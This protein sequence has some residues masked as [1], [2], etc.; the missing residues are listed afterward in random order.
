MPT[1]Y[2]YAFSDFG[3]SHLYK[4]EIPHAPCPPGHVRLK[5]RAVSLN[6]RD[7]LMIKGAYNPRQELPLIPC[8][9]GVGQ[10]TEVG[11]SVTGFEPGDRVAGV[12]APEWQSGPPNSQNIRQTRG[13]PLPGMLTQEIVLPAHG[14][15]KV[16]EFLTDTQAATL[17]CA[18]LTAY[19]ALFVQGSLK[20]T[21]KVLI[22]GSGGVSLF[23]LQ[24]AKAAGAT[25]IATSS[26]D[27]KL[28]KLKLYGADHTIN[29]QTTPQWSRAVREITAGQ[30]VDHVVE[31]GGA[32]TLAQSLKS[33]GVGGTVS[34]IGVLSGT[35]EELNVLPVLMN[36]IRIQGIFVG[37]KDGFQALN[38]YISHKQV[39]PLVSQVFGFDEA[40][41][42]FK[43]FEK[44][45]HIG[46]ICVSFN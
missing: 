46:K 1:N 45:L 13:G 18:G 41:E 17:P 20:R 23:A 14:V 33:V 32:G 11:D 4:C 36:Q 43:A 42:A 39:T 38:D 26:S 31:V 40:I 35:K 27:F 22:L 16:P 24:L 2:A 37:S 5:M 34:L 12:F 3:L 6:Y 44:G 9:D 30:G 21:Q 7:L 15:I 25:V 19:N 29:Y 10:I 28:E 8:S